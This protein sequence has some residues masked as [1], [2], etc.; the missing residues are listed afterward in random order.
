MYL[1]WK[2]FLEKWKWTIIAFISCAKGNKDIHGGYLAVSWPTNA[3]FVNSCKYNMCVGFPLDGPSF[4]KP[5]PMLLLLFQCIWYTAFPPIC[6]HLS[7]LTYLNI[8]APLSLP[9]NLTQV[10]L[11]TSRFLIHGRG[12]VQH[13]TIRARVASGIYLAFLCIMSAKK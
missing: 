10:P 9:H 12:C 8:Q 2:Y 7:F 5:V 3:E 11:I 4:S 13:C 6:G 1:Y